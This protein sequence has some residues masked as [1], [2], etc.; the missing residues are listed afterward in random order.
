MSDKDV[1]R[2]KEAILESKKQIKKDFILWFDRMIKKENNRKNAYEKGYF[3][4][5]N[6]WD[7]GIELMHAYN[8]VSNF[9]GHFVEINGELYFRLCL[10]N[11]NLLS[12]EYFNKHPNYK[13]K[14]KGVKYG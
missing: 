1:E 3:D 6:T 9:K 7:Q 11:I 4:N 5:V 10:P 12:E 13:I 14:C 2:F 8:G